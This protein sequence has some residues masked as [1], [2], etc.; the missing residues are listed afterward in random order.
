[1]KRGYLRT[2]DDKCVLVIAW[3][4]TLAKIIR[5]LHY[6]LL[7]DDDGFVVHSIGILSRRKSAPFFNK[8][9]YSPPVLQRAWDC[10]IR[11]ETSTPSGFFNHRHL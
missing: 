11:T 7:I 6:N 3:F 8:V 1:M 2:V 9:L 5:A 10:S 4:C